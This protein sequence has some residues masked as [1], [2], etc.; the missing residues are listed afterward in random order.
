M[1]RR[2]A[3][4]AQVVVMDR[5]GCGLSDRSVPIPSI[6]DQ[7]ADVVAVMDAAG[8]SSAIV[9]GHLDGGWLAMLCA[10]RYPERVAALVLE[11]TTPRLLQA[12]D[13]AFGISS[14]A[15]S[16]L[17]A[18]IEDAS[19]EDLVALLAPSR[20]GDARFT[21]WFGRYWRSGA[22][23]GGIR[24]LM[25][26]AAEVD[27]RSL[28]PQIEQPTLVLHREGDLLVD[29]AGARYLAD[30]IPNAELVVLAGADN[31]PNAGETDGWVDA[32]ERFVTGSAPAR[33]RTRSVSTVLFTDIVDS[34]RTAGAM[35]DR[36]WREVLELH[37]AVAEATVDSFQ[38]RVVEWTGDGLLAVFP[39]PQDGVECALRLLAGIRELGLEIRAGLHTGQVEVRGDNVAGIAVHTAAR[40]SASAGPG[41]V[42][43]S[44]TVKDLLGHCC[45]EPAHHR[46]DGRAHRYGRFALTEG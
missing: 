31:S 21:T 45:I 44:R 10:V 19:V 2:I 41:Q 4:F 14:V 8:V 29:V 13:Y 18:A 24:A 16:D 20:V 12:E 42:L 6:E 28:L 40:V 26:V 30:H 34:T 5:R 15:W 11:S 43:I 33:R 37:D 17:A 23:P 35:G 25:E 36:R 46:P 22:G 32:I 7:V 38:G 27:L 9:S 39:D 1:W 3:G